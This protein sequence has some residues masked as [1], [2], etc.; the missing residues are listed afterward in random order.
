MALALIADHRGDLDDG[1][2]GLG[3]QAPRFFDSQVGQVNVRRRACDLLEESR[4]VILR[5]VSRRGDLFER[6][7]AR[8]VVVHKFERATQAAVNQADARQLNL[9]GLAHGQV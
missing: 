1:M 5:Q 4:E 8:V 6:Q 2:R 3:Q 7:L 9:R